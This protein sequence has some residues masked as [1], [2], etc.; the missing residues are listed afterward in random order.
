M[1]VAATE[2]WEGGNSLHRY[3]N[4]HRALWEPILLEQ[5]ISLDTTLQEWAEAGLHFLRTGTLRPA[6][7]AERAAGRLRPGVSNA[8]EHP[9]AGCA[10]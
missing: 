5:G 10:T 8:G 3:A 7:Q 2:T 1:T 4:P 9:P 6:G